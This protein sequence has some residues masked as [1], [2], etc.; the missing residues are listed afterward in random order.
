MFGG[1]WWTTVIFVVL[2]FVARLLTI[3]LDPGATI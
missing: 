3:G 1:P 2:S